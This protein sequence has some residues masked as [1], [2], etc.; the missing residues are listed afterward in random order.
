MNTTDNP[1]PDSGASPASPQQGSQ[2]PAPAQPEAPKGEQKPPQQ[3]GVV[4]GLQIFIGLWA[5]GGG[6]VLIFMG[7][8]PL[9]V[10]FAIGGAGM[11]FKNVAQLMNR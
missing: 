5:L 3:P 4:I 10:I 11:L 8:T 9:G 6:V 7:V 2:A 1:T